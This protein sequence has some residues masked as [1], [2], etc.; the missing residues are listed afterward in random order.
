MRIIRKV[1][2]MATLTLIGSQS[3]IPV[4]T[5]VSRA[6]AVTA[7]DRTTIE[8]DLKELDLS[9]YVKNESGRH[10]MLTEA[11]F[12]EY[13]YTARESLS[14]HYGVYFYIYNPTEKELSE[15]TGANAVNM[16]V[17]YTAAG[18]PS[19]YVNL[20]LT[21]L[22]HTENKRFYKLRLT[23]SAALYAR[24]RA[25]AEAHAGKRRYDVAGIQLWYA[26][27]SNATESKEGKTFIYTGFA[28]G[29]GADPNA[30][31]TL[32][33]STNDLITLDIPLHHKNA[34]GEKVANQTFY[35]TGKS[36]LGA[37]HQ[38]QIDTVYFSID[39]T[40]LL[41]PTQE[42]I[43]ILQKI[44]AKW[45]EY[46]T[47]PI[48]VTS[49]SKLDSIYRPYIGIDIG[50]MSGQE[51]Y[52][53]F[54]YGFGVYNGFTA[55]I[56]TESFYWESGYALPYANRV[57][58]L[59]Q[60]VTYY[61]HVT[62]KINQ[63]D[64]F[65]KTDYAGEVVIPQTELVSYAENYSERFGTSTTDTELA[66]FGM[67]DKLF[68]D[69]TAV[70]GDGK[71]VKRGENVLEFDTDATFDLRDYD[72]YTSGWQKFL[73]KWYGRGEGI[74]D[75]PWSI[76]GMR[77][78]A[79]V[80]ARDLSSW[81]T[82]AELSEHL[83]INQ[84]TVPEFRNWAEAE[85][86]NGKKVY[87]FR[88]AVTDYTQDVLMV[89]DY[90]KGATNSTVNEPISRAQEAVFLGFEMISVTYNN[91][92]KMT[93][94]PVVQ[95]P[96]NIIDDIEIYLKSDFWKFVWIMSGVIGA[97]AVGLCVSIVIENRGQTHE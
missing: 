63:I 45:Y 48:Y 20:P 41:K 19:E 26:G 1:A 66:M 82:D 29:C 42:E 32:Q 7:Y 38:W 6:E 75:D 72:R 22:G 34:T 47:Q 58:G 60:D 77:P 37:N 78:I 17:T 24:M 25:Y 56:D 33:C 73:D 79:E 91:R 35:R 84:R 2:I 59:F 27:E 52:R 30:A 71:T 39:E 96:I 64:W 23:D 74:D 61:N 89:Q 70:H 16:A 14:R 80:T 49:S 13:G 57:T 69:T 46:Q 86:K 67:S 81:Y 3:I 65:F 18:M 4:T 68:T 43:G 94:I 93:I 9:G 12:M 36:S 95:S 31:G 53:N 21:V 90:R 28:K 76:E 44:K 92:G 51:L 5:G 10:E 62:K 88:F 55:G 50:S 15:R 11:G 54:G 97:L 87:L 40:A 83:K 85:I 8:D